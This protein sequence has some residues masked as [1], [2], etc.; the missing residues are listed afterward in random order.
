MSNSDIAKMKREKE[1]GVLDLIGQHVF[2]V[3][4]DGFRGMAF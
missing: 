4:F 1:K 3:E 2:I